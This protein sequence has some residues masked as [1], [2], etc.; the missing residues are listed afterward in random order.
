MVF[1]PFRSRKKV[2]K[3]P[4]ASLVSGR[5]LG[6]ALVGASL[7]ALASC[8]GLSDAGAKVVGDALAGAAAKGYI[9][10]EHAKELAATIARDLQ[11]VSSSSNELLRSIGSALGG[12][13]LG[14]IGVDRMH[15][16]K[17]NAS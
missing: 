2:A 5:A 6:W 17:A 13:L 15:K 10:P 16:R 9:S 14:A 12:I 3:V 7:L 1:G 4:V 11:A 8:A